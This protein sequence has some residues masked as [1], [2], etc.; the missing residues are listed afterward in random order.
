MILDA[1]LAFINPDGDARPGEAIFRLEIEALHPDKAIVIDGTQ[2]FSPSKE[3]TQTL[4]F[5]DPPP[6]PA[7]DLHRRA[8]TISAR[9]MRPV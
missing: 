9:A 8:V 1:Q 6:E 3:F 2:K 4:R 5:D 7:Q